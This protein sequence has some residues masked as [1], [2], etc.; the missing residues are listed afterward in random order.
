MN[1]PIFGGSNAEDNTDGA[2]LDDRIESLLIVDTIL[3][4]EAMNHPMCFIS[5]KGAI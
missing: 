1:G 3:L 2:E 5:C 4:S